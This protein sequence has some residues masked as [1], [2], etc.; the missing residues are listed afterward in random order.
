MHRQTKTIIHFY[1]LKHQAGG[2][3]NSVTIMTNFNNVSIESMSAKALI[4]V[5]CYYNNSVKDKN[6]ISFSSFVSRCVEV[7]ES[8]QFVLIHYNS[9]ATF[10]LEKYGFINEKKQVMDAI[11]AKDTFDA[12]SNCKH[13]FCNLYGYEEKEVMNVLMSNI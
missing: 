6:N 1:F 4:A 3:S 13:A 8:T 2:N 12:I 7:D 10:D 11:Q 5:L 9:N